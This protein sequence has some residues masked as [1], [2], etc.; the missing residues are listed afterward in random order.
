MINQDKVKENNII[1][2]NEFLVRVSYHFIYIER[3]KMQVKT[4]LQRE[5]EGKKFLMGKIHRLFKSDNKTFFRFLK[6]YY[7]EKI[8]KKNEENLI[9]KKPRSYLKN[10]KS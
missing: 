8:Y 9:N 10:K 2:E 1:G 7:I 6:R 4:S 3:E 5:K